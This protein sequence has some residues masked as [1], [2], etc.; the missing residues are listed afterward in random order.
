MSLCVLPVISL[1]VLILTPSRDAAP[2]NEGRTWRLVV[3]KDWQGEVGGEMGVKETSNGSIGTPLRP[4]RGVLCEREPFIKTSIKQHEQ[5]I[6]VFAYHT[7]AIVNNEFAA[8][9]VLIIIRTLK[10]CMRFYYRT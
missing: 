8:A 9:A 3:I 2:G 10:M 4:S 1:L 5:I 6:V 7:P